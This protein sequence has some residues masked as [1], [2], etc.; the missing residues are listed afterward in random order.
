MLIKPLLH[1]QGE[2]GADVV[3]RLTEFTETRVYVGLNDSETRRQ[4][5]ETGHYVALLKRV[6][7]D[8]GVP[9]SLDVV[10]GGYIHDDGEYTEENTI[11]LT[12]INVE[13]A[14]IDEMARDLCSLFHQESVLVTTGMVVA[15]SVRAVRDK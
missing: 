12:F 5:F 6:C 9:F 2:R 14:T 7:V 11:V 1:A 15:R 3:A 13:P 8:H 10:N 4:T